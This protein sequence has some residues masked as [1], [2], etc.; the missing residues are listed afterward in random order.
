MVK[1]GTTISGYEYDPEGIRVVKKAKGQ[2]IHYV[3]EGTEPVYE[4]NVTAGKVKSYVYA[5]GKHLARVDGV[6]GDLTAKVYFYHTDQLGS[7]RAI[8]DQSGKV[9]FNVDYFAFGAR[10]ISNGDFDEELG[11]TG[12]EYDVDIELYYYNARWYDP[13]TGRFISEDP[14]ADPNN[15]NLYSYC[16]NNPVIRTDSSGEFLEF[17][18][19]PWVLKSLVSGLNAA[20]NGGDFWSGFSYGLTHNSLDFRF[21][22]GNNQD[23]YTNPEIDLSQVYGYNGEDNQFLDEQYFIDQDGEPNGSGSLLRDSLFDSYSQ[24]NNNPGYYF[25]QKDPRWAN[26]IYSILDPSDPDYPQTIASSGCGPTS[27]AMAISRLTGKSVTPIT[28]AQYA[29]D[30]GYRTRNDG[31][32]WGFFCAI[33][34]HYGLT[35]IETTNFYDAKRFLRNCDCIVVASMG[36]GH[37]TGSGHYI[38]F[39]STNVFTTHVLDPNSKNRSRDWWDLTLAKEGKRYFIFMK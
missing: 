20:T 5:L 11:F 19:V 27:A 16:G 24:A 32:N 9:V 18:W 33:G 30:N 22:T 29:L 35:V 21:G 13:E 17:L 2:T 8:T 7:V 39:S 23:S 3:F 31:T 10:Y 12:K 37:F 34:K 14:A 38:V 26:I 36:P 15:P 4:K 6:I 25:S 1:Y 28:T